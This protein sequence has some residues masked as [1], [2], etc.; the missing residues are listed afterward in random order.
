MSY[1]YLQARHHATQRPL[2]STV[3]TTYQRNITES[4][5]ENFIAE[6]FSL[7]GI[8]LGI[9][10]LRMVS[11]ISLVGTRKLQLDDYLM[12]LAGVSFIRF[13]N[14]E[15]ILI[16]DMLVFVFCRDRCRLL[17]CCLQGAH[18]RR[19]DRRGESDHRSTF[20]RVSR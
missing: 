1:L 4:M 11:R 18:K 6:A 14:K 19:D 20:S 8:S 2:E 9:I 10:L 13:P 12:V 3:R 16:K 17:C 5:A 7:L 15:T